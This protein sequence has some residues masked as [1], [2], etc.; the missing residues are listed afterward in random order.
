MDQVG[1]LSDDEYEVPAGALVALS[2]DDA[3]GGDVVVPPQRVTKNKRKRKSRDSLTAKSDSALEQAA[4]R[5]RQVVAQRCSC[6]TQ[7]R[8]PFK[9]DTACF[10]SML[11]QR[12]R[13][14]KMDKLQADEEA[15]LCALG[16]FF[17][18]ALVWFKIL[19]KS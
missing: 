16:R 14:L 9:D 2:D 1:Q 4:S 13:L 8:K 5:L 17:L 7:C 12:V 6:T 15:I 18:P 3:R 19:R 11:R 10:E